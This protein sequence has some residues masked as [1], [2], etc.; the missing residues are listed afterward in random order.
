M[1]CLATEKQAILA[2]KVLNKTKGHVGNEYKHMNQ[3]NNLSNSAQEKDK[4]YTKTVEEKQLQKIK[5][6]Y[7][8]G[9]CGSKKH[10]I[11][12]CK[13]KKTDIEEKGQHIYEK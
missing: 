10:L 12:L 13:K 1:A 9:T 5:T 2:V 11:K 4:R 6:C 7:V 8:F 3:T